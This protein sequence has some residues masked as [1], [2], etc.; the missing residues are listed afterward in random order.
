MLSL[1]LRASAPIT[2]PNP[3]PFRRCGSFNKS[4][5]PHHQQKFNKKLASP[6][7]QQAS[8]GYLLRAL[9]SW[10]ARPTEFI[11]IAPFKSSTATNH[12]NAIT[13]KRAAIS[14]EK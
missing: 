12:I 4:F 8:W 10:R 13:D 7:N 3:N 14:V 2:A 11:A 5:I 1:T 9:P 6:C